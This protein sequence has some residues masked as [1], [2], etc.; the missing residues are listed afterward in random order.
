MS[1]LYFGFDQLP[2]I[3]ACVLSQGTFDGVHKGH[4]KVLQ[5][6][7]NKAKSLDLPSVL[8]T[9]HPHPR[10][11]VKTHTD[12]IELINSIEEKA[13][14]ILNIGV[15][16]VLV[17]EFTMEISQLSPEQFV[18]QILVD[19]LNTKFI[20][21]GYDHRFGKNRA[22][23]FKELL[24]LS[25]NHQFQVAEIE[26][27][28]IDE[29]AISSTQIR[30][31]L[32]IGDIDKANDLLGYHYPITGKVIHGNKNGRK[33]GFPTANISVTEKDKLIPKIGA[34]FG[35]T[36]VNGHSYPSM[37]NIGYRP[38]VEGSN[39]TIESHLIGVNIDL[40]DQTI[41]IELTGFL[42]E[43]IKFG[44]LDQLKEQLKTDK[45]KVLE[46]LV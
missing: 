20:L 37:I 2:N 26:A 46:V 44:S 8:L 11:V 45:Q 42:R 28:E 16:F 7:V 22:G 13:N 35:Y 40:Y 17:L 4:Q 5:S 27:K 18:T 24:K 10:S 19:K 38:T 15:N 3:D 30:K 14:H 9:F 1:G 33:L 41:Q 36:R 31:Y 39:L 23:G 43:E 32:K 21:V 12:K 6:L 25:L 29:I 34:Y